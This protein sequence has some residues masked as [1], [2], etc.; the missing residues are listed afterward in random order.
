VIGMG[1]TR[2]YLC[3]KHKIL[4]NIARKTHPRDILAAWKLMMDIAESTGDRKI[5]GIGV[6]EIPKKMTI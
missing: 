1:C 5:F 6:E 4:F 2:I 3:S